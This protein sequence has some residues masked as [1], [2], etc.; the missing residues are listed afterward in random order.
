[1][2]FH[3]TF[4]IN[5]GA[6]VSLNAKD[7]QDFERKVENLMEHIQDE[8]N[9]ALSKFEFHDGDELITMHDVEFDTFFD[10]KNFTYGG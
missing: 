2:K 3:T 8:V 4:N 1:M 9:K 10:D 5:S 6:G 7:K